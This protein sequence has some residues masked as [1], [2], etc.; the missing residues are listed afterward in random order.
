MPE[1]IWRSWE[2][3]RWDEGERIEIGRREDGLRGVASA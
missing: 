1:S 2:V 3:R